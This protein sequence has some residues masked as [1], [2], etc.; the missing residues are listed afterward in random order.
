MRGSCRGNVCAPNA[1][2]AT[3]DNAN[4]IA[5]STNAPSYDPCR[6]YISP[7]SGGSSTST[8]VSTASNDPDIVANDAAPKVLAV[9]SEKISGP[10]APPTPQSTP[11]AISAT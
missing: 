11:N 9:T 2:H 4:E 6:S 10:A 5:Y 7:P 8:N 1:R 3:A